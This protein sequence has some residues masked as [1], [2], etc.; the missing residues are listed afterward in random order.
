MEQT[1]FSLES[2]CTMLVESYRHGDN[3]ETG[4]VLVGQGRKI[5]TDVIVSSACADRQVASFYQSPQD[6]LHLNQNLR[7]FQAQ[8]LEFTGY[9]HR[10]PRG[11]ISLSPGDINTCLD[12]LTSPNYKINNSLIMVIITESHTKEFPVYTYIVS[13]DDDEKVVV[14]KVNIK[15]LPK[16]CILECF[17]VKGDESEEDHDTGQ[18]MGRTEEQGTDSTIRPEGEGDNDNQLPEPEDGPEKGRHVSLQA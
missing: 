2:I 4:G 14:K 5:V 12:I 9:W 16:R 11:L 7:L 8:G 17:D 3:L 1:I 6:V 18:R 15:V 10:H 13:L